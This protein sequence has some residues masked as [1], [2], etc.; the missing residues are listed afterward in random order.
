MPGATDDDVRWIERLM[1]LMDLRL[2]LLLLRHLY[3]LHLLLRRRRR[4]RRQGCEVAARTRIIYICIIR[5]APP[6]LLLPPRATDRAHPTYVCR[7]RAR[8]CRPPLCL[9]LPLFNPLPLSVSAAHPLARSL[10]EPDSVSSRS[11]QLWPPSQTLLTLGW[12]CITK[13]NAANECNH[14]NIL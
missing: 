3:L 4:R 2:R 10:S 9:T 11:G 14:T 1:G 7:A 13:I 6:L 12:M 5:C 8:V